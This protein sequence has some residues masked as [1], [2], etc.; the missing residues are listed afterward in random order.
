[1]FTLTL[2]LD[3][4]GWG[5]VRHVNIVADTLQNRHVLNNIFMQYTEML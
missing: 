4:N 5:G 3:G 1:M 2:Y